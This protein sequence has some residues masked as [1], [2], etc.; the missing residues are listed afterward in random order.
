[1][2]IDLEIGKTL[3]RIKENIFRYEDMK[4]VFLR[5]YGDRYRGCKNLS[6]HKETDSFI[7]TF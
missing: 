5:M 7:K 1:M 3:T 4:I 2:V 6:N